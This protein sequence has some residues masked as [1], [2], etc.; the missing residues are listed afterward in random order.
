MPTGNTTS[1]GGTRFRGERVD[2]RFSLGLAH[3]LFAPYKEHGLLPAAGGDQVANP[4]GKV[5]FPGH[6]EVRQNMPG[7]QGFRH[8]LCFV[9][10]YLAL[11]PDQL[12]GVREPARLDE[13]VRSD[14][15][16]DRSDKAQIDVDAYHVGPCSPVTDPESNDHEEEKKENQANLIQIEHML[17]VASRY[18]NRQIQ[19]AIA[20]GRIPRATS[21]IEKWPVWCRSDCEPSCSPSRLSA[22]RVS[23]DETSL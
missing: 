8:I 13:V 4:G 20:T 2:E 6:R 9:L 16:S 11:L 1:G 22:L 18:D 15:Y 17:I 3:A 10:R 5:T 23:S 19:L 7:S 12:N 14:L 21:L